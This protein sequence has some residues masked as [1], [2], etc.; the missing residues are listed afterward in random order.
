MQSIVSGLERPAQAYT[1][2]ECDVS[3]AFDMVISPPSFLRFSCLQTSS[4]A[5]TTSLSL[6]S[7]YSW[8]ELGAK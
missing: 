8:I 4:K 6:A 1:C 3:N 5:G 7:V 2:C